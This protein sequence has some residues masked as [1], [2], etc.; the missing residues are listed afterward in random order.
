MLDIKFIRENHDLVRKGAEAKG[1]TVNLGEII[2]LDEK[3]RKL[4]QEGEALKAQ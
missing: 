4:I 3:R 2:T 1:L